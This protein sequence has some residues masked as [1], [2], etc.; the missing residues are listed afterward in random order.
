MFDKL[1]LIIF[2]SG[3]I[4][5]LVPIFMSSRTKSSYNFVVGCN[6]ISMSV[7]I[8]AWML[9]ENRKETYDYNNALVTG[10]LAGGTVY[11]SYPEMTPGLGWI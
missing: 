1:S 8:I 9:R 10:Q 2:L 11:A 4:I 6:I 5:L 3:L 7:L